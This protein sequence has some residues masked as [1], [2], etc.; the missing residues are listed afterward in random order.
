[1]GKKDHQLARIARTAVAHCSLVVVSRYPFV[2]FAATLRSPQL[3]S[4]DQL[5]QVLRFA[6]ASNEAVLQELLCRGSL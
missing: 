5:G 6:G 3:M 2:L 1:L 4:F